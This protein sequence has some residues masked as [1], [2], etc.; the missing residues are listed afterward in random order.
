[1]SH[2]STTIIPTML[3]KKLPLIS[4]GFLIALMFSLGGCSTYQPRYQSNVPTAL[5]EINRPQ[6]HRPQVKKPTSVRVQKPSTKT[7][8]VV[9]KVQRYS[10]KPKG[11]VITQTEV[12][13]VLEPKEKPVAVLPVEV[14]SEASPYEKIPDSEV[15]S[16]SNESSPAVQSLLLRARADM[17]IGQDQSAISKLERALRIESNNPELWYLL[18]K[19][20][21]SSSNHQQA[22]TM[23]KKAISFAGS[24]ESLANKSWSLIKSSGQASGDTMVVQE[25]INYSKVYP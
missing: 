10:D 16:S 8:P 20:H 6:T 19:A 22:I 24:N 18:A 5:P 21:Q 25:A 4:L 17:L 11:A 9:A 14:A 7:K 15:E 13:A 2:N 23:A 3:N 12:R 1:M